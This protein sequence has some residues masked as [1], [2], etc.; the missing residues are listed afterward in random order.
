MLLVYRHP[1][2]EIGCAEFDMASASHRQQPGELSRD[3]GGFT[4]AMLVDPP[5]MRLRMR[6]RGVSR[7]DFSHAQMP[8]ACDVP[9][10]NRVGPQLTPFGVRFGSELKNPAPG[11]NCGANFSEYL[12]ADSAK[13]RSRFDAKMVGSTRFNSA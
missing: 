8:A 11:V 12:A 1:G 9:R 5:A 6:P 13:C 3:T 7:L 10:A 4:L 2:L